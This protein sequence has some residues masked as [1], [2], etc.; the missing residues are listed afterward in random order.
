MEPTQ[1]QGPAQAQVQQPAHPIHQETATLNA[2]TQWVSGTEDNDPHAGTDLEAP[3]KPQIAP[4]APVEAPKETAAPEQEQIELPEDEPLFE[5]EYKTDNGKESK[6]LSLKELR[7]GYLAKQDYHRNIQKVK[8]QEAE[9]STKAQQ[10]TLQA[11]QEYLQKLEQHKQLV[12]KTVAPELAQVDLNKLAQEDPAEAQRIFFKQ[13]QLN[14]TLQAI[15]S[16][17]RVAA[18]QHQQA[19]S[20]A[21]QQ[22]IEKAR[23]TLESDIPGWD[24]ATYN[25]VLGGVSSDYGFKKEEVEQVIDARLVKVFHD[26]YQYRQLQRAKPEVAKKVV[27]VPKVVKPGSGEKPN[28]A[29][30]AASEAFQKVQ[31]T[32][33]LDDAAR[34]YLA[35]QKQK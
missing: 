15:E 22:A 3:P 11:Q 17:Q 33:R 20:Q 30:E 28:T 12:L 10:A 31:K 18:Q 27:A 14:Q 7:E 35:M 9:L 24:A 16:E 1:A 8:A 32:G 5:I 29:N 25:K 4:E 6:K 13:L 34:A 23:Q 19:I 21:R 2:L 26:A